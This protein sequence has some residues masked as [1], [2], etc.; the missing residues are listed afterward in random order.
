MR[1]LLV[2]VA[3]APA[4]CGGNVANF[5]GTWSASD[6]LTYTCTPLGGMRSETGDST[7]KAGIGSDLVVTTACGCNTNWNVNGNTATIVVG[8]MCVENCNNTTATLSFDAGSITTSDGK[9]MTYTDSGHGTID[10][11]SCTFSVVGTATKVSNQ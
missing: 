6:T 3:I 9:S 1:S 8:Q 7:I 11:A 5:I 4:G 2:L 10:G